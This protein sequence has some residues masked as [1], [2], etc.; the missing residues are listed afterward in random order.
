MVLQVLTQEIDS[1]QKAA[2]DLTSNIKNKCGGTQELTSNKDN[3]KTK[4]EELKNQ[5]DDKIFTNSDTNKNDSEHILT[6]KNNSTEKID[7][8]E[9]NNTEINNTENIDKNVR[10]NSN[11]SFKEILLS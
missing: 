9:I 3:L 2:N 1:I 8:T 4:L 11:N 10:F 6:D 7:N 5:Y